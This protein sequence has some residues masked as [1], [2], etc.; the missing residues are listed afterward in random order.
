MKPATPD[1]IFELI[2]SYVAAPAVGTAMEY[3]LF[4]LL[5]EEPRDVSFVA[6]TL[7]IPEDRWDEYIELHDYIGNL[8]LLVA[9]ENEEKADS[10]PES[11]LRS[12]DTDFRK[13]HFIPDDDNLLN[14]DSFPEFFYAR[15]NLI[16]R[17]LTQ[18]F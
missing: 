8:Q 17:R 11:W 16:D 7:G 10:D 12:R 13:R 1:D 6:K 14:F 4:W 18:I 9:A 5:A 2:D 15:E 3:G